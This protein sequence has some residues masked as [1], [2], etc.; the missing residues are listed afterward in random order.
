M[1][2]TALGREV[3]SAYAALEGLTVEDYLF[4]RYGPPLQAQQLG[5]QVAD[6]LS[7]TNFSTGVAYG[8]RAGPEPVALDV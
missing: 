7:N 1:A 3:A 5:E 6:M 2:G 4:K 8:L